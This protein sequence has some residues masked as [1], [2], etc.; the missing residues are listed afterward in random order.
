M[1][2][3][4]LLES[5]PVPEKVNGLR[6]LASTVVALVAFAANSVLCRVALGESAIDAASFSTIRLASGASM[7][8]L[9]STALAGK[10]PRKQ[11]GD[12]TSASLLFL[13][14]VPFSYAYVTLSTGSGALILFGSV[15]AAM[16]LNALLSGEGPLVSEWLGL[17]AAVTGLVYLLFPGLSAPPFVGSAL[18]AVAGISWGLYSLR[19]RRSEDP[20]RVTTG[21][22]VRSVPFV[23]VLSLVM[24][25]STSVSGKGALLALLSGALTSGGGYVVW[26]Q[27]LRGLTAT[28]AAIVQLSVPVLAAIGGVVF[29]SETITPRL[30]VSTFI[31]LGGVGLAIVS[32]QRQGVLKSV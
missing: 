11:Y 18:M 13:Y 8:W 23:A 25:R 17:F 2:T 21:N 3:R 26:Y 4:D 32:R 9:T 1:V 16:I 7:L 10:A 24:W 22:F 19:G 31:I 15:Q 30:L 6:T 27:A 14:A 29:L 20:V 12:W 5:R 28:R